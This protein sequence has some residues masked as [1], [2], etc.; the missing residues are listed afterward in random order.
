LF[1]KSPIVNRPPGISIFATMLLKINYVNPY[2]F[3]LS[4]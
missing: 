3:D 4:N 2:I 1:P